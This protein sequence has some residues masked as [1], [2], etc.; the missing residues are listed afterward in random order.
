MKANEGKYMSVSKEFHARVALQLMNIAVRGETLERLHRAIEGEIAESLRRMEEAST[1]GDGDFIEVAIDE[2]CQ[3]VEELLGLAFVT[4][5][6]F[7]TSI[8]NEVVN[9]AKVSLS[10]FGSK[11]SF[12]SDLK[13]YD[14]LR[15]APM[16]GATFQFSV[17]EAINAIANYWKHSEEWPTHF[18]VSGQWKQQA[19]D[20]GAL[21]GNEKRTVEIVT[22]LGL[23]PNASGNLRTA[24]NSLG[25]TEFADLS[26]LRQVLRSWAL[27]LK[28]KASAELGM[29]Q[30]AAA[31]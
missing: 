3:A 10:Q 21:R 11:L 7:I 22:S 18:V 27:D 29:T 1:S 13:A 8:R 31:P 4:A 16:L 20:L 12:V 15:L 30:E 5:Q 14:T 6:S 24:A 25:I 17:V 23:A 19:W 28:L 2:E 9:I 26:R